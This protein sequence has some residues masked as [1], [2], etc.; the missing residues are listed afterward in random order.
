MCFFWHTYTSLNTRNIPDRR[1]LCA[2]IRL[3]WHRYTVLLTCLGCFIL[4]IV[5]IICSAAQIR[6]FWRRY[7]LLLTC[8]RCLILLIVLII[9]SAV[10]YY[11]EK[12]SWCDAQN[13]FCENRVPSYV[14][15]RGV[16]RVRASVRERARGR[17]RGGG[18]W[19]VAQNI[20]CENCGSSCV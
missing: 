19:C 11:L 7:T 5:L 4:L 14:Q 6:L 2:Q 1:N 20:L 3:F 17:K 10:L 18:R 12:G 15:S 8:L 16:E 13:N 9:C